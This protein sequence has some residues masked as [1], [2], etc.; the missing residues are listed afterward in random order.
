M[1]AEKVERT[2]GL[3]VA[4]SGSSKVVERVVRM[5]RLRVV[6][7]DETTAVS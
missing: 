3:T 6:L 2:V 7:R 5:E 4:S 1:A